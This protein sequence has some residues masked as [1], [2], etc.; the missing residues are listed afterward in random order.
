MTSA[1]NDNFLHMTLAKQVLAG[2][3]PV[4]DFF[5]Q[6]WVLQYG[7]SAAAQS[8][9]GD[10]LMSEAVI[11]ALAWAISTY[12]VFDLVLHLTGS[13]GAALLSAPLL[14]VAGARGYSYPKGIVYA[15]AAMLWWKY[16][17]RPS[18]A[19]IVMFGAWAAIAFYWRPD[20][21]I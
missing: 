16:V 6:G 7:L 8:I 14:I 1:T 4:R 15:I 19:A 18:A 11:V 5:D 2:D 3:W 13:L 10:R 9:G 12:V 17:R 21:G 20:H